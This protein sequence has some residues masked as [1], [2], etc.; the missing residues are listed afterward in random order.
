MNKTLAIIGS[1]PR[2]RDLFDYN[3]A[4]VDVWMFNEAMSNKVNSWVKRVDVIFQMHIPTIWKNPQNR[5]DPNHYN[6]LQTQTEVPVIYMQDKYPDVPKSVK[7]PLDEI[8][9]G[10]LKGRKDHFL[11]SSVPQAMALAAYLNEYNRVEIYGVAMETNTEWHFQREGVAFWRGYLEG[12]GIDVYFADPTFEAPLYGYEGE[13]FIKED[14]FLERKAEL[15]KAYQPLEDIYKEKYKELNEAFGRFFV[16]S[17]KPKEDKLFATLEEVQKSVNEMGIVSGQIQENIRY[18]QKAEEMKKATGD[19]VFSRQEFESGVGNLSKKRNELGNIIISHGTNLGN[20]HKAIA[21]SA[22]DSPKRDKLVTLY[23]E[24]MKRYLLALNEAAIY[25]GAS[26]ENMY[27][28]QYLDKTI[29]AAGGEKA[30]EAI[31]NENRSQS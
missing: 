2:T 9:N 11:T 29:R 14:K 5:N 19:F 16:D 30:E 1:H 3:R 26:S 17:S 13:V 21:T 15:E 20:A 24:Q 25:N 23:R 7:F 31:L 18:L 8:H 4:D 12:M 27:W 22:K 10:M 6:W 28:M